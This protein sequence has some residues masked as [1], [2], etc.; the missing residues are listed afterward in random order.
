MRID[1]DDEPAFGSTRCYGTGVQSINACILQQNKRGEFAFLRGL[2]Q[3]A[4]RVRS[5]RVEHEGAHLDVRRVGLHRRQHG[6]YWDLCLRGKFA[7]P[8]GVKVGG[9]RCRKADLRWRNR[10]AHRIESV[11]AASVASDKTVR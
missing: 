10:G 2:G 4:P 3:V 9:T 11:V 1:I 5:E 7:T 6:V 8:E